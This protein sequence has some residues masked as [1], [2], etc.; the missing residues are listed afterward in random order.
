VCASLVPNQQ[1]LHI[2]PQPI[3]GESRGVSPEPFTGNSATLVDCTKCVARFALASAFSAHSFAFS[4]RL[5]LTP[6]HPPSRCFS[7]MP[8]FPRV[9]M[10]TSWLNLMQER[11]YVPNLQLDPITVKQTQLELRKKIDMSPD[12]ILNVIENKYH[13]N[14]LY[15]KVW[16]TRMKALTK[17]FGDWESSYETPSQYLNALKSSYPGKITAHYC[18]GFSFG[19]VRFVWVFFG[20]SITSFQYCRP[21]LSTDGIY[22]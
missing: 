14:I 11:I 6:I 1:E 15:N 21:L 9:R 10:A 17:I 2:A 16:N 22:L 4:S 18:E 12:Y 13:I 8:L 5:A 3:Q 19:L 7:C 20:P